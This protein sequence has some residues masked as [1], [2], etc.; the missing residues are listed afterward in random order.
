MKRFSVAA[1][2]LMLA[3]PLAHSDI[4][5]TRATLR[6]YALK[7][8]NRDRAIHGLPSV[9]LDL[10]AS[11]IGDE[12][13][14]RQIRN[15]T[16]GHYTTDGIAPYMRYSHGGGNDGV[17]ENAAAWSANYTFTE[18]ALYEMTSRSQDAMMAEMPPADGHRR[19]ILDPH[20]THVGIGL[21]WDGGEF[22]FVQEFVRRYIQWTR[23][24][25]RESRIGETVTIAG[26]PMG[27]A[28][29]EGI[30]VHHEPFP[31]AMPAHVASAIDVYSL[32]AKRREYLPRLL[33]EFSKRRDGT[34]RIHR[35]EYADG[36]RGDFYLGKDGAFS[37]NVPFEDGP[38]IYTVVVWITRPG[39][40]TP[41]SASNLSIRVDPF[42]PG[43]GV[44]SGAR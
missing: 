12:Y 40:E 18:R 35:R 36:R 38:G 41:V 43:A 9:E 3:S 15:R 13:C 11:G 33:S 37:F 31:S 6:A 44:M 34:M 2:A 21:A 30:T 26:K 17:T 24:P 22:R 20:A 16:T 39:S 23:V 27:D 14:E 25:P 5:V 42:T 28:E 7:L 4:D 8:I 1:V 19:A 10:Q 29:I 32:P